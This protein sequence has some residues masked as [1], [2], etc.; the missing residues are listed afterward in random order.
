VE[1]A[2]CLVDHAAIM[3]FSRGASGESGEDG[4]TF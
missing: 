1:V 4:Q 2:D 3:G